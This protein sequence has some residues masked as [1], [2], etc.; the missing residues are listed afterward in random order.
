MFLYA[1]PI[2]L[3]LRQRTHSSRLSS[4]Y[5]FRLKCRLQMSYA[6][7]RADVVSDTHGRALCSDMRR[8]IF[9][10]PEGDVDDVWLAWVL[11]M[12]C[13]YHY[14]FSSVLVEGM[15]ARYSRAR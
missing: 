8:P 13:E 6:R 15:R 1:E 3:T 2:I 7:L 5:A 12:Y 4:W 10:L 11:A 9:Y 14:H